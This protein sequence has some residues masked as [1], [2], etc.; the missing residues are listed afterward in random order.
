MSG[1]HIPRIRRP[2]LRDHHWRQIVVLADLVAVG[3]VV[4][5]VCR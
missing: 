1:L 2:I 3:L 4:W 5:L